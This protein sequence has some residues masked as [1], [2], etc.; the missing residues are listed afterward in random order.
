MP[1]FFIIT[2]FTFKT[3]QIEQKP[4]KQFLVKRI[5]Q[6]IIPYIIF[7]GINYVLTKIIKIFTNN[8]FKTPLLPVIKSIF[9]SRNS[10]PM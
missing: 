10:M 6:L 3:I 7:E 1:V 8:E 5:H 4:I 2:G 9:F